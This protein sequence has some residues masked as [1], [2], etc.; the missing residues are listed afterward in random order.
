MIDNHI[1]VTDKYLSY[2][3]PTQ[4]WDLYMKDTNSCT[5]IVYEG[6][7]TLTDLK[8]CNNLNWI[9]NENWLNISGVFYINLISPMNKDIDIGYY[10]V[11]Q[12]LSYPFII[13]IS[14]TVNIIS[15]TGIS[16]FTLTMISVYKQENELK[17]RLFLL[18]QSA[19]YLSLYVKQLITAPNDKLK[20]VNN[21]TNDSSPPCLAVR[22]NICSQLFEINAAP[23]KC[24][25][26]IFSGEYGIRFGIKCNPTLDEIN[27]MDKLQ[28]CND[29][30]LSN[31][32][33]I[34]D[35]NNTI[36]LFID[37]E[38]QDTI[39]DPQIYLIQFDANIEFYV[40]DAFSIKQQNDYRIGIDRIY[41]SIVLNL[42]GSHNYDILQTELINV[43]LCTTEYNNDI[44]I[45]SQSGDNGGCFAVDIIDENQPYHIIQNKEI[46]VDYQELAAII[47]D[48][49]PE[50]NANETRFS[51]IVPSDISRTNLYIHSQ[52]K[53]QL[54]EQDETETRRRLL[55]DDNVQDQIRHFMDYTNLILPDP[56]DQQQEQVVMNS[57]NNIDLY[58][59]IITIS[60]VVCVILAALLIY[61]IKQHRRNAQERENRRN[62]Y[63]EA[64]PH[65]IM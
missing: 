46:N 51:F 57:N 23:I 7:F 14:K 22:N 38:F 15:K 53:I 40:D 61:I 19:D 45:V 29:W 37:I 34:N 64:E 8:Q 63:R 12:L 11:Y 24:A 48:N 56:I 1:G 41:V 33:K 39:C 42:G 27:D 52:I 4:Y 26:D 13:S 31:A 50:I 17:Y 25:N 30:L 18:T 54:I 10:Y 28:I 55:T 35:N 5:P 2:P 60:I 65:R 20:I 16:L 6:R 43:W 59:I 36:D 58:K 21:N 49:D 47:Y 32:N 9:N 44:L 3:K 62:T